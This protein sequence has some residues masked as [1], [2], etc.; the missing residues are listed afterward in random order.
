MEEDLGGDSHEEELEFEWLDVPLVET[1]QITS[2]CPRSQSASGVSPILGVVLIW[3]AL[4]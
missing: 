1:N 3:L 4:N 2:V